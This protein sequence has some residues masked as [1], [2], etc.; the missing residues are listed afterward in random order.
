MQA[1]T[2]SL[3]IL[4]KKSAEGLKALKTDSIPTDLRGS[5]EEVVKFSQNPDFTNSGKAK[6]D[7]LIADIKNKI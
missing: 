5:L 1:H 4:S 2:E 6:L 7:A 3:N